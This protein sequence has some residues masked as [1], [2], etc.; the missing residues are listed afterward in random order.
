MV[1][2]PCLVMALRWLSS[3]IV[4]AQGL[5]ELVGSGLHLDEI[6]A[7]RAGAVE[8]EHD[9]RTLVFF[10]GLG[11]LR[12]AELAVDLPGVVGVEPIPLLHK[13]SEVLVAVG[14]SEVL[15]GEQ[16]VDAF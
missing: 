10:E 13:F 15:E 8:D 2:S 14:P 11:V 3:D 12:R 9:H 4:A 5:D 7:K 16:V 6:V 1:T